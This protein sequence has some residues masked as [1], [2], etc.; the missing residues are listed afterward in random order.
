MKSG[1]LL[2]LNVHDD[3]RGHVTPVEKIA[4]VMAFGGMSR[5]R[6]I[7]G[8]FCISSGCIVTRFFCTSSLS[9]IFTNTNSAI[10]VTSVRSMVILA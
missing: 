8:R 10:A 1:L 4:F 9:P 6:Q 3:T 5:K 2:M 7:D